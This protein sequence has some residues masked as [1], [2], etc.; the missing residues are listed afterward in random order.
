[1]G[2]FFRTICTKYLT[3]LFTCAKFYTETDGIGV[4]VNVE[5]P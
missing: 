3:L 5:G 1:M 4:F 2:H